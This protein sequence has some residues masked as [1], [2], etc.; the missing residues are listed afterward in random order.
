M[1]VRHFLRNVPSHHYNSDNRGDGYKC[2][3]VGDVIEQLE[4]LP[5]SLPVSAGFGEPV[6]LTIY[7]AMQEHDHTSDEDIHLVLKSPFNAE[8][9]NAAL[10]EVANSRR[11]EGV[12]NDETQS[13]KR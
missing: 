11:S 9:K 8:V 10:L 5:R 3:T 2:R 1:P 12:F 4:K 7:N 13:F 6:V